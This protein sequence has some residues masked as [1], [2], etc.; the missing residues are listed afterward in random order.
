MSACN[1]APLADETVMLPATSQAITI[2]D[3]T[4]TPDPGPTFTPIPEPTAT[5]TPADTTVPIDTPS[6]SPTDTPTPTATPTHP[7]MIEVMRQGTYP[8]SDL[9]FEE[10]LEPGVNYDRY[11]VSYLSEGNKIFA[12]LT[13]P[14]G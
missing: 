7:L 6:P 2:T 14:W 12:L 13:I 11:I 4:P 1:Q 3:S 8:G 10:T 9:T 5:P